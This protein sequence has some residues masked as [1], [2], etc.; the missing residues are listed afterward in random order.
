MAKPK[1]DAPLVGVTLGQRIRVAYM[2]AGLNRAQFARALDV[3]YTTVFSWD[4]NQKRPNVENLRRIAEFTGWTV[5]QLLGEKPP[6][7]IQH[8]ALM[9]QA[10]EE[11][12]ESPE[13]QNVTEREAA[14]LREMR[15]DGLRPTVGLVRS[16]WLELRAQRS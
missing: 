6:A 9:E 7:E 1:N 15:I 14:R 8:R 11:F 10:V 12:L 16:L 13:G 2:R 3:A 5:E 4:R